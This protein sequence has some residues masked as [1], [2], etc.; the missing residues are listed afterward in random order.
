MY[1]GFNFGIVWDLMRGIQ[2]PFES[3][4]MRY[5]TIFAITI[6]VFV[7]SVIAMIID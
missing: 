3:V 7:S 6:L 1:Y 2:N 5:Q 4:R